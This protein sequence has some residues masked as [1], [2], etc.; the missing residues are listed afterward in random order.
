MRFLD[1][2][3]E[4]QRLDMLLVHGGLA[5]IWGR[6]RIGKT[7]LLLEWS[8]KHKGLYTVADQSSA[9]IQ[10]EYLSES[11]S[12][13]FSG[14]ND[15]V[16]PNWRAFLNAVAKEAERNHWSGPIIFDEFPYLV[17]A[18]PT[19]PSVFRNWIDHEAKQ[20]GLTVAIA[21]SSQ[22]MMQGLVLDASAPLYGRASESMRLKPLPPKFLSEVFSLKR[23]AGIIEIYSVWG[24]IPRYWELAAVYGDNLEKAVD[25]CV[26]DPLSPLH[27]E[28]DQLLQE[29][30][31]PA[32]SLR[33]LLD[34]IGLGA[35]RLSEIAGRL[36]K[37]QTSL[38][39]P[40]S[41]LIKL[42][43]VK[44]EL[45]FGLSEKTTKRSLYKGA[46]PFFRFWFTVVAPHR[47]YLAEA[48]P[49]M[50]ISLW[51]KYKLN[52]ISTAWEELCRQSI[53]TLSSDGTSLAKEGPWEPAGRYWSK[54]RPEWDIVARSVDGK[55]ILLGEAK[56]LSEPA[57]AKK[58]GSLAMEL[59]AKGIPDIEACRNLAPVYALFVP[60]YKGRSISTG[61]FVNLHIINAEDVVNAL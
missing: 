8:V 46:D 53:S 23:A 20:A 28:P 9:S 30:I 37:P 12:R 6:R 42:G 17:A 25:Q 19:L 22:R 47:A 35:N 29:E 38:G 40:L 44:R 41:R 34:T 21:G 50:R 49:D 11:F 61:K 16:Y 55:R 39:R 7:R 5:V 48:T 33:P 4:L 15:V 36:G 57:D 51:K 3:T 10:R 24:G 56:W 60:E 54:N 18:D 1:R 31:P 52:L 26:L 58:M 27:R 14:F 59:L 43:L 32:V 13:K 2:K 45:P